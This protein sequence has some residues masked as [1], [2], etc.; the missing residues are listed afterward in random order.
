MSK[1]TAIGIDFGTCYT[2]V[3]IYRNEKPEII[4]ND[5]GNESTPS[6]IAFTDTGILVGESAV[7]QMFENASNTVFD[8]KRLIGRRFDE[9]CVVS[10]MKSWPFQVVDDSGRPK[11]QVQFKGETKSFFPEEAAAMIFKRMKKTAESHLG[12][13][14]TDAVISV[15]AN[16]NDSQREATRNAGIIAGLNVLNIMNE[17]TAA[18]ITFGLATKYEQKRNVLVFDLGG[19]TFD[20]SILTIEDG[21]FEVKSTNGDTHLGGRD[22]DFR[23]A[24]YINKEIKKKHGKD[25]ITKEPA[26]HRLSIATEQ[27]KRNLSSA[28][29][30]DVAAKALWQDFD[31]ETSITR[32]RFED[33]NNDLFR[34]TLEPVEKALRDSMFSKIQIHEILVTGGS[35]YIPKVQSLLRDHF[36]R[37]P[38]N[39]SLNP[40]E[41]VVYGAAINAAILQNEGSAAIQDLLL[42]DVTPLSLGI[43][44]TGGVMTSLI[45]RNSTVPTKQIQKFTTY[46]DNQ[47]G[48]KIQVFE[49][50]RAMTKDNNLL[51]SFD[52]MDIAPAPRGVP[53][54]QVE[55]ELDKDGILSVSAVDTTTMT[56]IQVMKDKG[57]LSKED[58]NRLVE[59][60]SQCNL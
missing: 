4:K 25:F 13:E 26:F 50:E 32:A 36:D 24:N 39:K 56:A 20:V 35:M 18:A 55:F 53:Q 16:Y 47:E 10:D 29:S 1:A 8:I 34:S 28:S 60:M 17:P 38:L 3:A 15:P 46:A 52:L 9:P 5:K 30:S 27:A 19:G 31:L 45:K 22:F 7:D 48:I 33:L 40:Q 11:F 23:S 14:I 6:V 37:K 43:E 41:A 49:G 59:E 2:R 58:M 12:T 44:T 54:L 42:L 57:G 51:G 21:V